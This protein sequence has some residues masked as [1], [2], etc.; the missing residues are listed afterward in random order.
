MVDGLARRLSWLAVLGALIPLPAHA[1][2]YCVDGIIRFHLPFFPGWAIV[3]LV[4]FLLRQFIGPDAATVGTGR[5]L[6]NIIGGLILT[7]VVAFLGLG[8]LLF[9][10]FL[11]FWWWLFRAFRESFGAA[12]LDNPRWRALSRGALGILVILMIWGYAVSRNDPVWVGSFIAY[13]GGPVIEARKRLAT[14]GQPAISVIIEQL[15]REDRPEFS[16]LRDWKDG[17]ALVEKVASR[18]FTADLGVDAMPDGSFDDLGIRRLKLLD[19]WKQV[20]SS[21]NLSR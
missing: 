12:T 6:L 20:A 1:C 17:I 16:R 2:G 19:W 5:V 13:H 18:S 15:L 14:L 21:S 3:F 8:S 10:F 7:V 9:P 4:W 11:Y